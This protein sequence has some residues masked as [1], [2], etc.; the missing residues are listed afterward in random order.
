MNPFPLGTD[1]SSDRPLIPEKLY[2]RDRE[3]DALVT[4]FDRVVAH[5]TAELQELR[6]T[7][8]SRMAGDVFS[9]PRVFE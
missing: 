8:P 7:Q 2:G 1:D 9:V 3:V 5:G 4:A 6:I